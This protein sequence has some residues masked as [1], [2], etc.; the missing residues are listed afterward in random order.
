VFIVSLYVSSCNF[1]CFEV[2]SNVSYE[3]ASFGIKELN[4]KDF[5]FRN[6]IVNFFTL[7]LEF[8]MY[9]FYFFRSDL[10]A[11]RIIEVILTH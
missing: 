10:T 6:Y 7:S 3:L 1:P 2:G 9:E 4:Y 5:L 8:H 11:N